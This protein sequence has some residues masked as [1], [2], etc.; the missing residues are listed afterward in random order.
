M[1]TQYF[2]SIIY[3]KITTS[4][5]SHFYNQGLSVLS[6]PLQTVEGLA[7]CWG[8]GQVSPPAPIVFQTSDTS[9]RDGI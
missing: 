9:L 6:H 5:Y 3:I 7:V 2:E 4:V 1:F 8:K